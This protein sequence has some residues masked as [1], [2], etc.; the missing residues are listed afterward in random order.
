VNVLHYVPRWLPLS[1]QFVHGH[2]S[3]SSHGAVVVSYEAVENREAFPHR[4][5]VSLAAVRR[6]GGIVGEHRVITA[7][8]ATIAATRRITLVHVHFGYRIHDVRGLTTRLGLPCIVSLHGHDVTAFA[9]Q[10]PEHYGS[11]LADVDGVV[12]PSEYLAARAVELGADPQSTVVIP[13]GVDTAAFAP[14]PLPDGPP[15]VAFVGRLVEKKGIDVL[16]AAWPAVRRAVPEARLHIVGDGPLAPLV[17]DLSGVT[18]DAP[19]VRHRQM[20][21][22]DALRGATVVATPSR[23]TA[24]GDVESLLLVNLEAQASGRAVVSTRH[25]GIPEFVDEQR[26]AILVAEGDPRALADGLTRV[27]RDRELAVRLGAEGPAVAARADA[28]VCS[29]ALDA[30]YERVVGSTATAEVGAR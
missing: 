25:G 27:L 10:W 3:R 11:A 24:D 16:A 8:L 5:V 1:E 26:S 14:T 22:R 9:R 29:R 15:V 2:V 17:E 20:Q 18:V 6:L 28:T 21:V 12:V 23:T 4:P 30:L 13:S 7:T 19:D